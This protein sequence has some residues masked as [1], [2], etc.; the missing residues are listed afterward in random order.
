MWEVLGRQALLA[1]P[2]R[3][4][5][6]QVHA[7]VLQ[8]A[9]AQTSELFPTPHPHEQA[10]VPA[11]VVFATMKDQYRKPTAGMWHLLCSQ[12]NGGMKPGEV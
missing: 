6:A 11:L 8:Q 4:P 10:G 3:K 1:W 9:G 7:Y 2:H 5:A 12:L